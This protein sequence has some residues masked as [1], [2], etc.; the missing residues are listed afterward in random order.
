MSC[1][2]VPS[3]GLPAVHVPP[4][5]LLLQVQPCTCSM[6]MAADAPT[7]HYVEWAVKVCMYFPYPFP[8]PVPFPSSSSLLC[9][10][11]HSAPHGPRCQ[12]LLLGFLTWFIPVLTGRPCPPLFSHQLP[13]R[14][15]ACPAVW[16]GSLDNLPPPGAVYSRSSLLPTGAGAFAG[17]GAGR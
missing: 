4:L 2:L 6:F 12:T 13:T 11:S 16:P 15:L 1:M 14:P 8:C 10:H 5:Q 9:G 3:P 7:L 17:D